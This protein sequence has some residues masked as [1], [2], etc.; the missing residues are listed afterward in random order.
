MGVAGSGKTSMK[1]L[2]LNNP[3]KNPEERSS[4]LVR[5]RVV[6]IQRVTKSLFQIQGDE[7][8]WKE[9]TNEEMID[10][11][12]HAIRSLP[13]DFQMNF[14]KK[15][16]TISRQPTN[17][18]IATTSAVTDYSR[19]VDIADHPHIASVELQTEQSTTQSF[20]VERVQLERPYWR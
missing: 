19:A 11:L 16:R 1:D 4:T 2:L 17:S 5:D 9:I 10:L 18:S 8:D 6:H 12:A 15:I 3:P 20:P 14:E 13:R 7:H